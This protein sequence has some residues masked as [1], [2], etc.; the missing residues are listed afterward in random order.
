[1]H[2][3]IHTSQTWADTF[4]SVT[5]PDEAARAEHAGANG[6]VVQGPQAGGHSATFDPGGELSGMTTLELTRSVRAATRLP[7]IAGGG[8]DGPR[9]VRALLDAGAEAVA[10]GTLLLRTEQSG[11]SKVH[12]NALADPGFSE[13]VITRAFTG[14]PARGLRN[15]F[16]DRHDAGAPV[17]Y[18]EIHHLTSGIRKA[19][20]ALGDTDS[21]HLWAGT[22][23]RNATTE[24]AGLVVRRLAGP[25]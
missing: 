2:I 11:A 5:T 16:I 7:I 25:V 22:G 4:I 13:T 15:G 17:G 24:P 14:R 9:S 21:V 12:K 23:F 1:M 8:V 18:P 6:L 10:V 3:T 19:A 20:A